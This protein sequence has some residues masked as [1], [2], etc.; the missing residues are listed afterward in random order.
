MERC[1]AVCR[2][3]DQGGV[4]YNSGPHR[5]LCGAGFG[6]IINGPFSLSLTVD[7][8]FPLIHEGHSENPFFYFKLTGQ[9]F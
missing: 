4:F 5:Y 8:G 6:V 3:V 2:F 7:V 9:P 1:F